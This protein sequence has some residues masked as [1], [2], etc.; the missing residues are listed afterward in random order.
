MTNEKLTMCIN[1]CNRFVARAMALQEVQKDGN[2]NSW[3]HPSQR[4][5]VKRAS[6]DLTRAL[7]ELRRG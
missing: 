5:A 4:G 2:I 7:A 3:E 6:M 1:E